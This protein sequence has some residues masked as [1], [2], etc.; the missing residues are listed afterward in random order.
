[1]IKVVS[2]DYIKRKSKYNHRVLRCCAGCRHI[3]VYRVTDDVIEANNWGSLQKCE[4]CGGLCGMCILSKYQ[5]PPGFARKCK[6]CDF[7]FTCATTR[8]EKISVILFGLTTVTFEV[9]GDIPEGEV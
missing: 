7:K 9:D 2:S 6:K 5:K 3:Q 4:V 8:V 1:M